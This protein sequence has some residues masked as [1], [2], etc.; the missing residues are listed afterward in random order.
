M[1]P[2]GGGVALLSGA[3]YVLAT[4]MGGRPSRDQSIVFGGIA[5]VGLGASV[6]GIVLLATR[7]NESKL[8]PLETA[9]RAGAAPR[10]IPDIPTGITF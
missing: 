5:V 4:S 8:V 1:I 7:A 10:I 6:T 3:M 9:G 2:V